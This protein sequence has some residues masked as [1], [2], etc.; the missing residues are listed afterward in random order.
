[1]AYLSHER[2]LVPNRVGPN[3]CA[4]AWQHFSLKSFGPT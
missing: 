1:M 3:S 2:R 4:A